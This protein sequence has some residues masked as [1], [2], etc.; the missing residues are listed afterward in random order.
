MEKMRTHGRLPMLL[1]PTIMEKMRT[2]GRL[3]MLLHPT[4]ME[5]MRTRGH[6]PIL[7]HLPVQVVIVMDVTM[8]TTH[9]P[10]LIPAEE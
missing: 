9:L 1:H 4:I 6:L 2:H 3:P 10:L 5:K 7:L 8:V